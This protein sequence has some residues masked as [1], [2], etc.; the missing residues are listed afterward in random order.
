EAPP[1]TKGINKFYY[2]TASSRLDEIIDAI[3]KAKREGAMVIISEM[4]LLP[5][6]FLE[7]RLN[8]VLTGRS[9]GQDVNPGFCIFATMNTLDFSGREKLSSAL[10]NRVIYQ[11]IADYTQDEL[12]EFALAKRG[13]VAEDTAIS[14]VNLHAWIRQEI[15][16]PNQKPTTRELENA[17][18]LLQQG[19]NLEQAVQ[20]VYGAFY[21]KQ[22][23]KGK[24]YPLEKELQEFQENRAVDNK[25]LFELIGSFLMGRP[26]RIAFDAV[27]RQ[28]GAMHSDGTIALSTKTTLAY[29]LDILDHEAGHGRFTRDLDG[30]APGE[31]DPFYWL[32]IWLEDKRMEHAMKHHFPYINL[33]VVSEQEKGFIKA[34]AELDIEHLLKSTPEDIF[35]FLLSSFAKGLITQEQVTELAVAIQGFFPVNIAEYALRHLTAA[36]KIYEAV[37]ENLGEEEIQFKQ[38]QALMLLQEIKTDYLEIKFMP[39]KKEE[40]PR[41]PEPTPEEQKVAI[42]QATARLEKAEYVPQVAPPPEKQA[43]SIT[44]PKSAAV[45]KIP[46]RERE[47]LLKEEKKRALAESKQQVQREFDLMA[48]DLLQAQQLSTERLQEMAAQLEERTHQASLVGRLNQLNDRKLNLHRERIAARINRE[49]A[50]RQGTGTEAQVQRQAFTERAQEEY[51]QW[52]RKIKL[53]WIS[54]PIYRQLAGILLRAMWDSRYRQALFRKTIPEVVSTGSQV[55][56]VEGKPAS[57]ASK[58]QD[59]WVPE[60]LKQWLMINPQVLSALGLKLEFVAL[61]LSQAQIGVRYPA[62]S[63]HAEDFAS[64]PVIITPTLPQPERRNLAVSEAFTPRVP[65]TDITRQQKGLIEEA[66]A[67]FFKT[68]MSVERR[69]GQE[70]ALDEKRFFSGNPAAAFY[71]TGGIEEKTPKELVLSGL[72]SPAEWNIILEEFFLFLF[73]RGFQVTAYTSEKSYVS[74]IRTLSDLKRILQEAKDISPEKVRED[75]SL[76]KRREDYEYFSLQE[77]QKKIEDIYLYGAFKSAIIRQQDTFKPRS[78]TKEKDLSLIVKDEIELAKDFLRRYGYADVEQ[79]VTTHA[80]VSWRLSVDLSGLDRISEISELT[81]LTCLCDLNLTGTKISDFQIYALFQYHPNR[82]YLRVQNK[83]GKL[84][85]GG[86]YE[87]P[88]QSRSRRMPPVFTFQTQVIEAK[89]LLAR[90]RL[91][92]SCLVVD[93][94]KETISLDLS[95]CGITHLGVPDKLKKLTFLNLDGTAITEGQIYQC[96]A[97]HPNRKVLQIKKG[98]QVY[99]YNNLPEHYR[100]ASAQLPFAQQLEKARDFLKIN[101][102][103]ER[104]QYMYQDAQSEEFSMGFTCFNNPATDLTALTGLSGLKELRLSREMWSSMPKYVFDFLPELKQVRRLELDSPSFFDIRIL[105]EMPSLREL[106]ITCWGSTGQNFEPEDIYELFR[107]HPQREKLTVYLERGTAFYGEMAWRKYTY[108]DFLR[109][110]ETKPAELSIAEQFQ[111]VKKFLESENL[112]K[113]PTCFTGDNLGDH[114]SLDLSKTVVSGVGFL[115]AMGIKCLTHLDLSDTKVSDILPLAKSPK[116]CELRLVNCDIS[117]G[118]IDELF[119]LHPNRENLRVVN[120]NGEEITFEK[121]FIR[122]GVSRKEVQ[123]KNKP[124]MPPAGSQTTLQEVK[125][126]ADRVLIGLVNSLVE[127]KAAPQQVYERFQ[128]EGSIAGFLRLLATLRQDKTLSDAARQALDDFFVTHSR[129]REVAEADLNLAAADEAK[130]SHDVVNNYIQGQIPEDLKGFTGLSPQAQQELKD[131][132]RNAKGQ[133]TIPIKGLFDETGQFGHIGVGQFYGEPVMYVDAEYQANQ[134]LQSHE[135]YEMDRWLKLQN[136]LAITELDIA[137]YQAYLQDQLQKGTLTQPQ[138]EERLHRARSNLN[139]PFL[140]EMMRSLMIAYKDKPIQR[141]VTIDGTNL[142]NLTTQQIS[143]L[144]HTQ[145]PSVASL[146][147]GKTSKHQI[148]EQVVDNDINLSAGEDELSVIALGAGA[149]TAPP[150]YQ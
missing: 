149:Q 78:K 114:I 43:L 81:G 46:T 113:N 62:A 54:F 105:A 5:T 137:N 35:K 96:L 15:K 122:Q 18:G 95:F 75:L 89:L 49:I 11:R 39:R 29:Q 21:L 66:I 118:Q 40:K 33:D 117:D 109:E 125:G 130:E 139:Q 146:F 52:G 144:W 64:N 77:L 34:V 37:P 2:L 87:L 100:P 85:S 36:Q 128:K 97:D 124:S 101:N 88:Y 120:R 111:A 136:A 8:D 19:K 60:A 104:A 73:A 38:Y 45:K 32:Y 121:F 26:V 150:K 115:P 63:A 91:P 61:N 79:R 116:L 70:G 86:L 107:L 84:I 47:R 22:V 57:Q 76:H 56:G 127:P 140:P 16:K 138:A 143:D 30:L 112:D 148:P 23:L 80:D 65:L 7:G 131:K 68:K 92:E 1:E 133:I 94:Q 9:A 72:A 119:C 134:T 93:L 74:G 55:P 69:Y 24:K 82:D 51:A 13:S 90:Y 28:G 141:D 132:Y 106:E 147:A 98:F 67:E 102:Q 53:L 27:T 14:L 142:N 108:E 83:D 110:Y 42:Q 10:Q 3:A 48:E 103:E 17:L 71:R 50:R 41:P 6:A 4:N 44:Q 12:K 59:V 99:S 20:E 126:E 129:E 58:G 145:A 135:A 123:D 31:G 25:A